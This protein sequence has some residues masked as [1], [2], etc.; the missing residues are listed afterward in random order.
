MFATLV[1]SRPPSRPRAGFPL[2]AALVHAALLSAAVRTT[3]TSPFRAEPIR[4]DTIVLFPQVAPMPPATH[5]PPPPGTLPKGGHPKAPEFRPPSVLPEGLDIPPLMWPETE[6]W[7]ATAVAGLEHD[8]LGEPSRGHL[9]VAAL[10]VEPPTRLSGPEPRYPPA[11]ARA[12]VTGRVEL[13][14]VIDVSGLVDSASLKVLYA[15]HPEFSAAAR[16]AILA[17]RFTPG[18]RSGKPVSVLV[19]Q[20]V[21]FQR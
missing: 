3:S 4:R 2:L 13:S 8:S 18:L 11:L 1:V 12:G 16:E 7:L 19:R 10:D 6:H 9:P 20:T 14:F 17:S 21:G 5:V 15:D